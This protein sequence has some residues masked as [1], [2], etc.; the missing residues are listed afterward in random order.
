MEGNIKV[1]MFMVK[2]KGLAYI[3][4]KMVRF[5]KGIGKMEIRM[6]KDVLYYLMAAD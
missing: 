1:I 3:S 6:G 5:M 4:L 2:N